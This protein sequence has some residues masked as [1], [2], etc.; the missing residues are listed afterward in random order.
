[1]SEFVSVERIN[2]LK[3][4]IEA[5]T[6]ETYADLTA[7]V[8]ALVDGYGQGGGGGG[9]P[10]RTAWYRPPDMPD[11]SSLSLP[12]DEGYAFFTYDTEIP[13]D[14]ALKKATFGWYF[15]DTTTFY[16]VDV[17]R[18]HIEN[19]E[20]VVDERVLE[21]QYFSQ[22]KSP[23]IDLP[24]NAGRF[25]CYRVSTSNPKKDFQKFVV[26]LK[27]TIDDEGNTVLPTYTPCVESFVW[28]G[29]SGVSPITGS[30]LNT[31]YSKVY[32]VKGSIVEGGTS[33]FWDSSKN[34]VPDVIIWDNVR[35]QNAFGYLPFSALNN[36]CQAL[37]I[38]NSDLTC[39]S[40]AQ[41]IFKDAK[42]LSI[43]DFTGTT[44]KATG[45]QNC[46]S[47]C[48]SLR[49]LDLSGWDMSEVTNMTNA[50]N[51]CAS[52]VHLKLQNLP[53]LAVNFSQCTLLSVESLV[54]IIAA[55]PALGD[56]T[57]LTCTLGA[58]NTAKL[59]EDQIA[60]ATAKGWTIA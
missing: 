14:P 47:G 51:G 49:N 21:N 1:M 39:A 34:I 60:V 18:G 35:M 3:S 58:T 36:R 6:G 43:L 20:F 22:Q 41:N 46:F 10:N 15:Y 48:R 38:L 50:F 9:V 44:V 37:Y 8:Q 40:S 13:I 12:E 24:T 2:A 55:L 52:L 25:I 33:E 57:T 53:A 26:S 59:T 31:T 42:S 23:E 45:M 11:Y 7:G 19:G 30:A 4:G 27:S 16:E 54:G 5:K 17:D 29:G 56:G 32:M 28:N